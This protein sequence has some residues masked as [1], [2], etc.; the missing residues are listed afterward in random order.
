MNYYA[1]S[2]EHNPALATN[3]KTIELDKVFIQVEEVKIAVSRF[4]IF[5]KKK[6]KRISKY[7]KEV[8]VSDLQ[9][10]DMLCVLEFEYADRWVSDKNKLSII[11]S[12][13]IG[14]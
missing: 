13:V 7:I 8:K 14:I 10:G 12:E 2:V 6:Q 9:I 3:E 11:S 5:F 4:M 1:V